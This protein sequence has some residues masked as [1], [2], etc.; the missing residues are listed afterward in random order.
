MDEQQ[1]LRLDPQLPVANETG[2][3]LLSLNMKGSAI[4]ERQAA[5]LDHLDCRTRSLLSTLQ[6]WHRPALVALQELGGGQA[7]V[8]RLATELLRLGYDVMARAGEET[9]SRKDAHRRGG[10]LL[11][12]HRTQFRKAHTVQSEDR[13]G[14]AIALLH[15]GD[16]EEAQAD[17]RLTPA[18][19]RQLQLYAGRRAF[20]IRLT[21]T[22][23][24]LANEDLFFACVYVP[25]AASHATRAAFIELVA[26]KVITLTMDIISGTTTIPF[27]IAG[28][29]NASPS[30]TSRRNGSPN[31]AHDEALYRRWF[32]GADG[33]AFS[34]AIPSGLKNGEFTFRASTGHLH[35]RDLDFVFVDCESF[36]FWRA[37]EKGGIFLGEWG[38]D[39]DAFDHRVSLSFRDEGTLE[40]LGE[41]RATTYRI[42]KSRSTWPAYGRLAALYTAPRGAMADTALAAL[43]AH[44][45]LS[46]STA[47]GADEW[48]TRA[49]R[50]APPNE[51]EIRL[52][53]LQGLYSAVSAS[54]EWNTD[55]DNRASAFFLADNNDRLY[56][57][58]ILRRVRDREIRRAAAAGRA[59]SWKDLRNACAKRLRDAIAQLQPEV[60]ARRRQLNNAI[61]LGV[62]E[63]CSAQE[64]TERMHER[65]RAI[66]QRKKANRFQL[67]ALTNDDGEIQRS[68]SSVHALAHR[69]GVTQNRLSASDDEAFGTWLQMLVPLSP[70]LTLPSGAPWTLR[71]ALPVDVLRREARKQRKGKARAYQRGTLQNSLTSSSCYVAWKTVYTRRTTSKSWRFSFPRRRPAFCAWSNSVTFGSSIMA[72]NSPNGAYCTRLSRRSALEFLRTMRAVARAGAALNRLLPCTS[73]STMPFIVEK[74][75]TSST[76]TSP[77][78]SCPFLARREHKQCAIMASPSRPFKHCVDSL[79]T[80]STASLK[81]GTRRHL[82]L[83]T[84]FQS[85]EASFKARKVHPKP[86]KS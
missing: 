72:L 31:E 23:G 25:A 15:A 81:D 22:R 59:L 21:R 53:W 67:A 55:H 46:A 70:T 24:P 83:P 54:F 12:W 5:G 26:D 45:V 37:S 80:G 34:A 85:F 68:A 58:V 17:G 79:K 86:A 49:P 29:W 14:T 51:P 40:R 20:G 57:A 10:V 48:A 19:A 82:G 9:S 56:K 33:D 16:I 74:L 36:P 43:E 18:V 62:G 27:A 75:C 42:S 52:Q 32:G 69:Y 60:A 77:S 50:A 1:P 41:G 3:S 2:F 7:S 44:L 28:D 78:A 47:M 61:N 38:S 65:L 13:D 30:P 66:R 71:D 63:P 76:S 73:A 84:L 11:A 4:S 6:L 39:G 64:F 35:D 8:G